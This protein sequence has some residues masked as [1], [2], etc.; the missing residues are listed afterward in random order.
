MA[1]LMDLSN[2]LIL[3]ICTHITYWQDPKVNRRTKNLIAPILYEHLILKHTD[4][5]T[6]GGSNNYDTI[7]SRI[8]M[9]RRTL[10]HDDRHLGT[11]IKRKPSWVFSTHAL[12]E[13]SYP[14]YDHNR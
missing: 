6:N 9:L 3:K 11:A 1:K 13:T 2:E 12:F 10:A 5:L 14:R 8:I 7:T 4:Y